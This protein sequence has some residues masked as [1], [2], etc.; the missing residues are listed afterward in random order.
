VIFPN[1]LSSPKKITSEIKKTSST[2]ESIKKIAAI[3]S[4]ELNRVKFKINE[5]E[6]E[7]NVVSK[8]SDKKDKKSQI[9]II[10]FL[11]ILCVMFYILY[12]SEKS[13]ENKNIIVDNCCE[14]L[15]DKINKLEDKL[16]ILQN[17]SQR[18]E[19]MN[20]SFKESVS[21]ENVSQ[22]S[23]NDQKFTLNFNDYRESKSEIK[24]KIYNNLFGNETSFKL[25]NKNMNII[26]YRG[27]F[28]NKREN[29]NYKIDAIEYH[30]EI[31]FKRD[32]N[33][34]QNIDNRDVNIYLENNNDKIKIY[35]R[36]I[37]KNNTARKFFISI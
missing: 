32:K 27:K 2:I 1:K 7:L 26:T 23:N 33:D 31:K 37:D 19:N 13:M 20:V 24:E 22:E 18:N 12:I 5:L 16:R 4:L 11:I 6:K 30:G 15:L 3:D 25:F 29:Q 9:G 10:I 36:Y 35:Y 8:S 28:S 34:S 17:N 14:E 21:Q